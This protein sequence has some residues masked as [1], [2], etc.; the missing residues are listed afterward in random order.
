MSFSSFKYFV[1]VR[2]PDEWFAGYRCKRTQ[3]RT[4]PEGSSRCRRATPAARGRCPHYR[5][6]LRP[7]C[8]KQL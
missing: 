2:L 6:V 8:P 7:Y 1:L 4:G 5:A 3:F